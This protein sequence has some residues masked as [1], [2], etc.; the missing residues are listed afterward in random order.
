MYE[1]IRFYGLL[2]CMSLLVFMTLP[3]KASAKQVLLPLTHGEIN[4]GD[5]VE[6]DFY[7]PVESNVTISFIAMTA[8]MYMVHTEIISH[9]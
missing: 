7:V 4:E 2:L 3:C 9:G 8:V 1:K 5:F 6:L